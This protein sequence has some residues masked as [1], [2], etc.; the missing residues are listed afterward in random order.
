MKRNIIKYKNSTKV[1]TMLL[2]IMM[3]ISCDRYLDVNDDPN[4]VT[5]NP[6]VY[7]LPSIEVS[8]GS[9][10]GGRL[11]LHGSLWAQYYNQNNTANQYRDIIDMQLVAGDG[12]IVWDELYASALSDIE[13]L[14]EYSEDP[15]TYNP[16]L[17]FMATVLKCYTY[18]VIFDCY[19]QAPFSE[20]IQGEELNFTP[21]FENGEDVYPQLISLI[22]NSISELNTFYEENPNATIDLRQDL[23]GQDFLF[24]GNISSWKAFANSVKLK[25][26]MR[27]LDYDNNGSLAI[28]NS[29][30]A[31][32]HYLTEDAMLDIFADDVDKENPLYAQDQNL[33]TTINLVA[34]KTLSEFLTTN[35]DPRE[36]LMF[37]ANTDGD[38]LLEHG[39]HRATTTTNPPKSNRTL[40][41]NPTRP[42][43]L[44]TTSEINFFRAELAA[45]G[46]ISNDPKAFYDEAVA[47]A[48]TRVGSDV[49][50]TGL[51][52]AGGNYE[53]RAN[54]SIEDQLEDIGVQKW[55]A[56]ANVN[57]YEG[58]LEMHRL[59]Y[60]EI[61]ETTT[62]IEPQPVGNSG[63][64]LYLPK[65]TVLGNNYVRRYLIPQSEI[66]SNSQN[67]PS[68]TKAEDKLWWDI[69]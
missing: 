28:I 36:T 64:K 67:V 52:D 29:L 3:L 61:L 55:A 18:Q 53:Y 65:N 25:I 23:G 2:A 8:I 46:I 45:R 63:A 60:P 14:I 15:I 32:N 44:L 37:T 10:V 24:A 12:D 6:G 49:A 69:N 48:F 57:P 13:K 39:D 21:R 27:N 31:E 30:E 33:N 40:I 20:A 41:W 11:A 17:K 16:R 56:M 7:L 54:G 19:G 47:Q 9:I 26:A 50:S 68:Q 62:Y 5:M 58:F 4:A 43:Y 34:N 42:V 59:D 38:L 22:D 51:I 35:G 66:T 1:L